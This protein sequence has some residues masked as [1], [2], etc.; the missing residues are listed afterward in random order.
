MKKIRFL[1]YKSGPGD[2]WV[3]RAIGEIGYFANK[4]DC[5]KF[6]NKKLLISHEE[7]EFC[8]R[9]WNHRADKP[10][11]DLLINKGKIGGCSKGICFSSATRGRFTGVRLAPSL[12][13]LKHPEHWLKITVN[14]P[15][16]VEQ[17]M[18]DAAK[19][20]L[21]RP[22]DYK[23]VLFKL[24]LPGGEIQDKKKWY[25]SEACNYAACEGKANW[26]SNEF[27]VTDWIKWH[28]CYCRHRKWSPMANLLMM[29]KVGYTVQSKLI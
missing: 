25:C 24:I 17:A 15:D 29:I 1:F 20:I 16:A 14:V 11:E 5:L 27:D 19:S 12:E 28:S 10:A 7:I 6:G 2:S 18:F 22:Y 23:G 4:S 26:N 8:D 9:F 3:S 13:I 21:G